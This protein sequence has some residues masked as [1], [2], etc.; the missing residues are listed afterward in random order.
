MA[1]VSILPWTGKEDENRRMP[2]YLVVRHRPLR[3]RKPPQDTT[4]GPNVNS[5]HD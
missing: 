1:K 3:W 2:I 5:P 4:R